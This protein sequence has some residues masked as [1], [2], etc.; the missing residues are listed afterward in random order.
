M[1]IQ[2]KLFIILNIL[3]FLSMFSILFFLLLKLAQF[4]CDKF[5]RRIIYFHYHWYITNRGT[6]HDTI[7][8]LI[9]A[10]FNSRENTCS[11]V[12]DNFNHE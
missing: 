3:F 1:L 2:S 6:L 4:P 12:S 7:Q 9:L 8:R 11:L 5:G 10:T